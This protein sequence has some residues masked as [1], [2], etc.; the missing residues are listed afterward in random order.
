MLC[1]HL[2]P[3]ESV[4]PS[5]TKMASGFCMRVFAISI[6]DILVLGI[7]RRTV[8]LEL[9]SRITGACDVRRR[10]SSVGQVR[11]LA[12]GCAGLFAGQTHCSDLVRIEGKGSGW[13]AAGTGYPEILR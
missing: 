9:V 6:E 1:R 8:E 13:L 10:F 2:G 3:M 4:L 7:Q 5:N 12:A 11:Q